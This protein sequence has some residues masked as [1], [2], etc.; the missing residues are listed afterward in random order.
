MA[1]DNP[2]I[3][4][5]ETFAALAAVSALLSRLFA[6][7]PDAD[8]FR[9]LQDL[10]SEESLLLNEENADWKEGLG[11]LASFC[12]GTNA[13]Q[14]LIDVKGDHSALFVGPGHVMAPPWGSVHLDIGFLHGPSSQKVI[15]AYRAAGLEPPKPDQE[16]PDH[17]AIEL[18]FIAE[19]DKR[20]AEAAAK[21]DTGAVSQNLES[22]RGFLNDYVVPW[23]DKFLKLI[24]EHAET[25]FYRGLAKISR[26][27]IE[28]QQVFADQLVAELKTLSAT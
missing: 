17:I 4:V 26:A 25:D 5:G 27:A 2:W 22:L 10:D 20:I 14:R 28:M 6:S 12:R 23:M 1:V 9:T 18:D 15:A 7:P 24:E 3:D 21:A 19:L 13:K 8:M 16:P 11:L